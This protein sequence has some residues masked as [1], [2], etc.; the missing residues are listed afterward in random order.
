MTEQIANLKT[1]EEMKEM[2]DECLE[3]YGPRFS[4]HAMIDRL[5]NRDQFNEW[6]DYIYNRQHGMSHEEAA[7]ETDAKRPQYAKEKQ[8]AQKR[9]AKRKEELKYYPAGMRGHA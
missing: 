3:Q 2:Y 9:Q 5:D 1:T 8:A 4:A 7:K 6:I